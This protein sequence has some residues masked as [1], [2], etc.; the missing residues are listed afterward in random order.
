MKLAAIVGAL[1]ALGWLAWVRLSGRREVRY[2][3]H[4]Q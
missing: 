4:Q 3:L 1:L 2:V